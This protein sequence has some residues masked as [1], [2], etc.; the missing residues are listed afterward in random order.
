MFADEQMCGQIK[1]QEGKA[2]YMF[3]C[4]KKNASEVSVRLSSGWLSACEIEALGEF[5]CYH[6]LLLRYCL[7]KIARCFMNYG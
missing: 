7:R 6:N 3:D 1:F 2:A 5:G 4:G